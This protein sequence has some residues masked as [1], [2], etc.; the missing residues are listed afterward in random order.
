MANIKNFGLVGV[1]NEVQFGKN[2]SQ[3]VQSNGVFSVKN[4]SNNAFVRLQVATPTD[5]NDAVTKSFLETAVSTAANAIQTELNTVEA[6]I[7]LNADGSYAAPLSSNYLGAATSII[8]SLNALD[9]KTFSLQGELDTTQ[10]GAGLESDGHL[11][12][13]TNAN[14]LGAATSLKAGIEA[15]DFVAAAQADELSTLT[16]RVDTA[17]SDINALEG[18]AT[19][20]ETNVTNVQNELDNTQTALGLTASGS[21][22]AWGSTYYISGATTTL[23]AG[24]EALDAGLKSVYDS[25][26]AL[27]N[28]LNYVGV[29]SGGASAGA[30]TDLSALSEKDIGDLYKVTA[31]GWFNFAGGTAFYANVGD[32]LVKNTTANGWDKFDNTDSTVQGVSNYIAVTGSTDVGFT[33]DIDSAFKTRVSTAESDI[34]ALEG[35]MDTAESDIN[36]LEGRMDTAESDIN[37]LEGRA[38]TTETNVTSAQTEIDAIEAAVGLNASGSFA[39]WSSTNYLN[40]ATSIKGGI[41]ALD[42][43]INTVNGALDTYKFFTDSHLNNLDSNVSGIQTEV[44]TVEAAVGLSASGSFVAWSSTNYLNSATSIKT[45][46]TA[47]DTAINTVNGALD[48]YKFFTDS[49]LN[50]LD[51]NVSGIQDE[52]DTVEAAVGLSASGSFVAW[53]ATNYLNSATSIKTGITAL[54]TA[55][56]GVQS[57][58]DTMEAALGL[59]SD[60]SFVSFSGTKYLDGVTT[61]AGGIAA[62]DAAVSSAEVS[63]IKT[64]Y[65]S[66]TTAGTHNIGAMITGTV[67]RVKVQIV[68]SFS[69]DADV[70]VGSAANASLLAA[71]SVIDTSGAGLYVIE[72]AEAVTA[73]QLKAV[74]ASTGSAKVWIEY[75]QG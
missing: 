17:E 39:A 65:A 43:A 49:H 6:A 47:L 50:N 75:M 5:V 62:L 12:S 2:G 40:S 7:G 52:V 55:V 74:L 33:V 38:T 27:G 21:L 36:A 29:L 56:N 35:R 19:T 44:D 3:I 48:T 69:T 63:H 73:T 68:T 22:G 10:T 28:A 4:A 13:W 66:L 71:S 37:A 34:N 20:T 54:D 31:A 15:L 64:L 16:G 53:S 30:A 1:G 9:N 42:T 70:T 46:I 57:E 41:T 14:Y 18:R 25:V 72:T 24:V 11:G 8:G 32:A 51:S 59:A 58:V 61:L 23:K 26:T 67:L 45:G 60:G